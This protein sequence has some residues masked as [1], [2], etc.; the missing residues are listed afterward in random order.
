MGSLIRRILAA[1]PGVARVI[2]RVSG[3]AMIVIGLLLLAERLAG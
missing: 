2:S 1:R 3:A